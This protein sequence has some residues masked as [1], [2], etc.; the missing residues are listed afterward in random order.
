MI[1]LLGVEEI[2]FFIRRVIG[3]CERCSDTGQTPGRI[4]D[5]FRWSGGVRIGIVQVR[6]QAELA[7]FLVGQAIGL[8]GGD[9]ICGGE[10]SEKIQL[11]AIREAVRIAISTA[12][13][14][15]ERIGK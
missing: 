14:P 10:V 5:E 6:A 11:P 3:G 8:A 12:T 4:I 13:F 9:W 2:P 1:G 15:V 7:F